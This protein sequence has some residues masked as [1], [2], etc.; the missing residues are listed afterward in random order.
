[1]AD[2]RPSHI[3]QVAILV[4]DLERAK[5]FYGDRLGL[6]PWLF[7]APPGLSFFQCGETRLMLGQPEGPETAGISILYYRARAVEA[8]RAAHRALAEAGVAFESEPHCIAQVGD[9]DLWLGVCR[10][11]TATWSG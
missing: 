10:D 7:D 3:A 8:S 6:D 5:T 4:R 11:P 9:K 2:F 1:M